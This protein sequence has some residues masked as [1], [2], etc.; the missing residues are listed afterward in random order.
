[1]PNR[2]IQQRPPAGH[3]SLVMHSSRRYHRMHLG[4][5]QCPLL[6]PLRRRILLRMRRFL[7]PT[8][9]RPVLLDWRVS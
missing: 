2:S 6:Y 3:K 8:L 1:M 7:R 5:E 9:R 4:D